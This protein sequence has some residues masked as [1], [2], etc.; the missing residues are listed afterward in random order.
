M[1]APTGAVTIEIS[2]D[3][4]LHG[5]DA[6]ALTRLRAARPE[7]GVFVSPAWLS[8][9][10]ADPPRHAK[11]LL[12]LFREGAE[13]RGMAPL[14]VRH[15]PTH[16]RV[17]LLG[18]GLGSDRVDLVATPGFE[19]ACS[20]AL[21]SWMTSTF[22][23]RALV[24]EPRG[25]PGDSPL[26][27]ALFRLNSERSLRLAMQT[28]EM[29]VLPYLKLAG[30]DARVNVRTAACPDASVAK[31][32]RWL[33]RRGRLRVEVLE[34]PADVMAAFDSLTA[35]L[36]ARWSRAEGGSVLDN[37]RV[38]RFHRHV[39]PRLL[40][41]G[42]LR[43][44]RVSSD[45]RTVA[46]FYGLANGG[47]WGY[48]LCGYDREWAGRIHLGRLTLALALE[49]ALREGATEFDFLQGVEPVKY[50]WPVTER[51]TL[52]ADVYTARPAA[53]FR[54][55]VWATREAGSAFLKSARDL[56]ITRAAR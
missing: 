29:H 50:L 38:Q 9:Y 51:T 26:W 16:V 42:S 43:M 37:P 35:F 34:E 48:Y 23:Y 6:D 47:W 11:P 10:F 7:T 18:G 45:V 54:R 44:I 36:H 32:R 39:I 52:D 41:A 20:N 56:F 31:H 4:E 17:G 2:S 24:F 27:G 53:Q 21:V 13:L 28:R 15:M 12:A 49:V 46:V 33:E 19:V 5:A 1:I 25:V 3:L 8:G 22:G 30:S 14:A 40:A 55:V